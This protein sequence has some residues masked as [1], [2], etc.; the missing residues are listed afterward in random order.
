MNE[1]SSFFITNQKLVL[2]NIKKNT[3]QTYK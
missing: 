1:G 3:G 2:I